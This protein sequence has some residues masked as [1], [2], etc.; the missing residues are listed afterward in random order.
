M[1][2]KN[3]LIGTATAATLATGVYLLQPEPYELEKVHR[4]C[5][6][7]VIVANTDWPL[8]IPITK[9]SGPMVLPIIAM[10]DHMTEPNE[11]QER[12]LE[13][14]LSKVYGEP[15]AYGAT[16]GNRGVRKDDWEYMLGESGF[17][18]PV[19]AGATGRGV[20]QPM[21]PLADYIVQEAKRLPLLVLT[22]G[23]HWDDAGIAVRNHPEICDKL[24][25]VGVGASNIE[26]EGYQAYKTVRDCVGE[27]GVT[28]IT[29]DHYKPLIRDH[30]SSLWLD[31]HV[32][33]KKIGAHVYASHDRDWAREA[34][35]LNAGQKLNPNSYCR[36]AD[37]IALWAAITGSI[38]HETMLMQTAIGLSRMP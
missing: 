30:C 32:K 27:D 13:M 8:I 23:G 22:I 28:L 1:N 35:T 11:M 29:K 31:K 9:C 37:V 34:K 14:A 7:T 6:R 20:Y 25:V 36:I 33:S 21:S 16:L 5:K 4:E 26:D 10:G 18:T 15:L 2:I 19:Y 12:P 24:R 3:V 17:S 38:D